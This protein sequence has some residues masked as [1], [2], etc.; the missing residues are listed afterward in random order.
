VQNAVVAGAHRQ[1]TRYRITRRRP[2][3]VV[4]NGE[5]ASPAGTMP[6]Q[7]KTLTAVTNARI[8]APH[9]LSVGPLPARPC[10]CHSAKPRARHERQMALAATA[11]GFRLRLGGGV[12]LRLRSSRLS[13]CAPLFPLADRRP[14]PLK[15]KSLYFCVE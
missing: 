5:F 11:A 12:A 3:R 7:P 10:P 4:H 9:G 14:K 15:E 6:V 1:Q 2:F 13:A 8:A